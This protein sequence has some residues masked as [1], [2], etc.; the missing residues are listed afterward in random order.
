M[1][2]ELGHFP[3]SE[4]AFG[5]QT[6]Y[7]DGLLEIDRD[8]LTDL[9]LS[10]GK[11][12]WASV[13][14]VRPGDSAR[15]INVQ[16]MFAVQ[17]KVGGGVAYP[18]FFGRPA[19]TV[20]AGRTHRLDNLGL[21]LLVDRSNLS[22]AEASWPTRVE[23]AERAAQR[24]A[25][26]E[27]AG[28]GPFLDMAG[29]GSKPPYD[30]LNLIALTLVAPKGEGEE[31]HIALHSA[32]LR[33]LDR[34]AQTVA[35]LTPPETEV[36]DFG[37]THPGL[38]GLVYVPHLASAEWHAGARSSYGTGVYGQTRLSAPWLLYPTEMMD[39]AV[40]GN[41]GMGRPATWQLANNPIVMNLARR[42]GKT[43]S[44]LSC[45][46]QR[47]NWTTQPEKEMAAN[48]V[49]L[50]AKQLGAGGAIVTT[51]MRGQRFLETALTV[52]A[53]ER[54][55]IKTVLLTEE[56]DNEEGTAPPLLVAFP[57]IQHVVSAGT[58]GQ[59]LPFP[60]IRTVLG[61]RKP[62]EAWY[63]ERPGIHGSYATSYVNDYYGFGRESH[64]DY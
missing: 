12:P 39:G 40:L 25:S 24:R 54:A 42:H 16:D 19:A 9:A 37:E 17:A 53:C 4:A 14:I 59:E 50:M 61:A 27:Q 30:R 57:E 10:D 48:R 38:P 8:E 11:L 60:A 18:G 21:M 34:L 3:V 45:I 6:R 52:Q 29:P 49:A 58:G 2:L 28:R 20:G 62:S 22:A 13:D 64:Q 47:T 32:A 1:R 15:L 35:A 26:Q 31:R 23:Q 56:E 44:F 5:S 51:D 55:G 41:Y 33:L 63:G 7:A 46:I 43:C 36:F